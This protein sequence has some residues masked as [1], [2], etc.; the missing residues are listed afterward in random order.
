VK[1]S[2]VW[3]EN[4]VLLKRVVGLAVPPVETLHLSGI[5]EVTLAV[6]SMAIS[7]T[8]ISPT[9]GASLLIEEVVEV[10]PTTIIGA[11]IITVR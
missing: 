6:S 8:D 1:H 2:C 9:S 7:P 3:R 11:S 4:I 10:T 5:I